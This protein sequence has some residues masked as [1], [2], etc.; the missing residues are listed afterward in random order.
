MTVFYHMMHLN[1][2]KKV[3]F[4]F[5]FSHANGICKFPGQGKNLSHSCDLCHSC[6]NT[7]SK[8]THCPGPGANL[9]CHRDNAG[10]STC[11]ATA[12]TPPT[13]ILEFQAI[14]NTKEKYNFKNK[15][16]AYYLITDQ[17]PLSVM[18]RCNIWKTVFLK[19]WLNA[20]IQ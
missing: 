9:H 3:L 2:K 18:D 7:R 16:N 12:G 10:T 1:L 11:C 19:V 13:I 5:F 17:C 4:F 15:C 14:L 20:P 6:G 8:P